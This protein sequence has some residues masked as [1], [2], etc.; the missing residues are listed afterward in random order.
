MGLL[1]LCVKPSIYI[2]IKREI[3]KYHIFNVSCDMFSRDNTLRTVVQTDFL[4]SISKHSK[5]FVKHRYI[6]FIGWKYF[7]R[8]HRWIPHTK[9]C[10]AEFWCSSDLYLNKRLSKQSRRLWFKTPLRSLWRDY[11]ALVV[12]TYLVLYMWLH[13]LFISRS[14]LNT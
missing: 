10:D 1:S 14:V 7:L 6:D 13:A 2:Q 5:H 12:N 11:N 3:F 4:S 8:S 9:A